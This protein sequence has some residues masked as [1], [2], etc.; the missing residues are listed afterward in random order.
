MAA[1]RQPDFAFAASREGCREAAWQLKSN[2]STA[3]GVLQSTLQSSLLCCFCVGSACVSMKEN[4]L[5]V[6][7]KSSIADAALFD[8]ICWLRNSPAEQ[9]H[10]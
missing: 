10:K 3:Q 9:D 8:S 4:P 6:Q 7:P 2:V 1:Q 5:Q